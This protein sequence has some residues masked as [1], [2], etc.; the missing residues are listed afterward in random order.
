MTDHPMAESAC[1][2]LDDFAPLRFSGADA[3]PFLQGQLSNDM[4]RLRPGQI[5]RA[6]FHNPQGRTL[7]LLWLAAAGNDEVL[8]LLPRELVPL[9]ASQLKRYVLRAKVTVSDQSAQSRVVG[10]YT[11]GGATLPPQS[12]MLDSDRAITVLPNDAPMPAGR[13]LA[14]EQWRALDVARG[15]PQ[16]HAAT[17]GQF[18]AQMLNLDCVDAVSFEKGC[19]TGQEV[20]AR[21]HFRGRVKRRMQRFLT[22][23]ATG[24]A[25][26]DTG[27]LEDGRG[28][29]VIEAVGTSDGGCEFLA[30]AALTA[31]AQA[32]GTEA[33]TAGSAADAR[34][35]A[36]VAQ[37][38]PLPY[39]LPE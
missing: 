3:R 17:S 38:L 13:Q 24:L 37:P 16:V 34:Q 12:W 31:A 4:S 15:L 7:A 18:I 9:V 27:R 11:A 35:P 33:E 22:H 8:A 36:L 32:E 10:H 28:F 21:A 25:A 30:V 19:Y 26:G 39:A 29:R 23:A 20:I 14:R 1:C 5:L 6:G 2:A